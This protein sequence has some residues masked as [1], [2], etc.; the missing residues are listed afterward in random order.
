MEVDALHDLLA[1]ARQILFA[2]RALRVR[3]TTDDK[4]ICAW[5]ALMASAYCEA[6]RALGDEKYREK[7]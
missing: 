6:N 2:Q 4:T 1:R 7:A 3:P 5:N